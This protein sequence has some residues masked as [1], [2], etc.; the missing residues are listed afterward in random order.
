MDVEERL[1][2]IEERNGRVET[3]KAWETSW[4]RALAISLVTYVLAA[5]IFYL[6]DAPHIFRNALIPTAGFILS[7]LSLPPLKRFWAKRF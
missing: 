4:C 1:R 5:I 2:I 3:D 6:I 7:T